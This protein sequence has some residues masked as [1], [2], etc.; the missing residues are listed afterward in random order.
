MTESEKEKAN[1]AAARMAYRKVNAKLLKEKITGSELNNLRFLL[2]K[3]TD[4]P[5]RSLRSLRNRRLNTKERY[6]LQKARLLRY[7]RKQNDL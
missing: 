3:G 7:L 5:G 4:L 6:R 2:P 1:L